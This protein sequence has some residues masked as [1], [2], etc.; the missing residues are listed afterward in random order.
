MATQQLTE[1]QR[2]LVNEVV[3]PAIEYLIGVRYRLDALVTE[4][5]NQQSPITASAD[6]LGDGAGGTAARTDAPALTGTN[7]AQLRTF[8]AGMRDQISG[9]ALNALVALSV[10]DVPRIVANS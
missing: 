5:D 1:V 3:R 8:V 7:V 2:T 10:R 4:L 9:T 6:I